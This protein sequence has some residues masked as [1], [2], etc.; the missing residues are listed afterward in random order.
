[1]PSFKLK[2]INLSLFIFLL[3]FVFIQTEPLSTQTIY[4][5]SLPQKIR[6]FEEDNSPSAVVILH[7]RTGKIKYTYNDEYVYRRKF[8][9][10]S[11]AKV[12][13]AVVL[14]ENRNTFQFSPQKKID[15]AGKFLFPSHIITD[16]DYRLF[17]FQPDSH[18]DK[19][20]FA[21]S[22]RSGHHDIDLR[23]ALIQSCNTYFLR[24]VYTKQKIFYKL[25]QEK[26]KLN[27]NTSVRLNGSYELP[28]VIAKNLTD[29]QALFSAI[30]EGGALQVT[31]LKVAQTF[32][33]F[34][35]QT[36]ML[37]PYKNDQRVLQQ[38]P[39]EISIE[40]FRYIFSALTQVPVSGT[41]KKMKIKNSKVEVIAGKTGSGTHL[42]KKYATHGWNVIYFEYKNEKY[43]LV[44]FVHKGNGSLQAR[45]LSE[46]ILNNIQ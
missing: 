41:L 20:Y 8:P 5:K 23:Q 43:T 29:S 42:H 45:L 2:K 22:L 27:M 25:L 13:T 33:A 39:L 35:S 11:I 28:S 24:N 6:T 17:N 44:T 37:A 9:P 21:C 34:F 15:C 19:S 46:L 1:M 10:G 14:M 4:S 16:L 18:S 32:S 38:Y 30:G 26:W 7:A 36:P 3:L 12:W 31:P 40:T